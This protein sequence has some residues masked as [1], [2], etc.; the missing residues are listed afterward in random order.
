MP[1]MRVLIWDD[2]LRGGGINFEKASIILLTDFRTGKLGRISLETPETRSEM[3][4]ASEAPLADSV[5]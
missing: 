3:M 1:E 5:E 2:I 4:A